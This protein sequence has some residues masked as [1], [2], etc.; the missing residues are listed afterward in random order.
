MHGRRIE[1]GDGEGRERER[2]GDSGAMIGS[3]D[4]CIVSRKWRGEGERE[5]E[6]G[7][8]GLMAAWARIGLAG[9]EE[10]GQAGEERTNRISG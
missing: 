8:N 5:G 9:K 2:G 10:K 7:G 3:N 4:L 1:R 6:S